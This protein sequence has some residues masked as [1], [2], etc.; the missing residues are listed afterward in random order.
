MQTT[1]WN[2]VF[3]SHKE[4][5][6]I[7]IPEFIEKAVEAGID[8]TIQRHAWYGY[9]FDLNTMAKSHIHIV[10]ERDKW[11]ALMRYNEKHEVEDVADLKRLGRHA[12][13]GNDYISSNWA[14]FLM[15]D[16]ERAERKLAE[17]AMNKL[18]PEELT[19]L[20]KVLK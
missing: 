10:K 11:Y 6:M 20:K 9:H 13:H 18:S 5:V 3:A 7:E 1:C 17:D 16:E 4:L 15:T 14:E 2:V 12:M 19:A 8:V